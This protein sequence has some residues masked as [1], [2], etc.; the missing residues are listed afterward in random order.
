MSGRT[1]AE[2]SPA[3]ASPSSP[4]PEMFQDTTVYNFETLES[5]CARKL[6]ERG[7]KITPDR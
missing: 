7:V 4:D 5:V 6:P 1:V 2:G 3:P